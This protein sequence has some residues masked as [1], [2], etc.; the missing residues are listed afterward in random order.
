[1]VGIQL[2]MV[3]WGMVYYCH[4]HIIKNVHF[5]SFFCIHCGENLHCELGPGSGARGARSV[6]EKGALWLT[7]HGLVPTPH[8]IEIWHSRC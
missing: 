5:R 4:T 6:A 7:L 3:I 2:S 1:M 8:E